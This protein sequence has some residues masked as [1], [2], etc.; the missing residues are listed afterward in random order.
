MNTTFS[1]IQ[2]HLLNVESKTNHLFIG[3]D[4]SLAT[5]R[6]LH[7]TIH[8]AFASLA[9]FIHNKFYSTLCHCFMFKFNA[10]IFQTRVSLVFCFN[11]IDFFFLQYFLLFSIHSDFRSGWRQ[12]RAVRRVKWQNI[13][14]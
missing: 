8:S 4:V 9:L 12:N 14:E 10:Y 6:M 7:V 11:P 5:H 3:C 1:A 13:E 2:N